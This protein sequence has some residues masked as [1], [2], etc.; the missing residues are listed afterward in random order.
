MKCGG[1]L[2]RDNMC[3]SIVEVMAISDEYPKT[4]D[5]DGRGRPVQ[6]VPSRQ[7]EARL[8]HELHALQHAERALR[9]RR[10]KSGAD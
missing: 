10:Q 6:E 8:A 3:G 4:G 7:Y 1:A 2:D 9:A 5:A